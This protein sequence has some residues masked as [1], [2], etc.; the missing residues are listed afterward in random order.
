MTR[1]AIRALLHAAVVGLALCACGADANNDA[2]TTGRSLT[3]SDGDGL[4][5]AEEVELGTDPD[6]ADTD[7]DGVDDGDEVEGRTDPTI[8]GSVDEEELC[9]DL[10]EDADEIHAAC[11]EP[12][13]DEHALCVELGEFVEEE[14]EDGHGQDH[15]GGQD[16]GDH[17][18]HE[19]GGEDEDPGGCDLCQDLVELADLCHE[20]AGEGD[21]CGDLDEL[22]EEACV[23]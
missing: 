20:W 23:D 6:S 18:D 5:D 15:E 13:G 21:L 16:D 12:L 3:D 19:G 11:Y 1:S 9:L 2:G 17:E 8:D 22:A 10:C 14:C 4:T 7:G